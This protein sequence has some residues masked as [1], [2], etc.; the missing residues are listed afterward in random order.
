MSS[1]V[2]RSIVPQDPSL[3]NQ[4]YPYL[5][6]GVPI[7]LS[8]VTSTP[9]T[10]QPE[11]Y[12]YYQG[13]LTEMTG[14]LVHAPVDYKSPHG[15]SG[16][17][18]MRMI[19]I[20]AQLGERSAE[21]QEYTALFIG[22]GSADAFSPMGEIARMQ[23]ANAHSTGEYRFGNFITLSHTLG[24]TRSTKTID[25]VDL[26][27][28]ANIAARGLHHAALER[29]VKLSEDGIVVIG[30]SAGAQMAIELAATL[31]NRC[32][33]LVIIETT[34]TADLPHLSWEFSGGN[35]IGLTRKAITET[36]NITDLPGRVRQDFLGSSTTALGTPSSVSDFVKQSKLAGRDS[37][38]LGATYG[39]ESIYGPSLPNARPLD[40]DATSKARAKLAPHVPVTMVQVLNAHVA[41]NLEARA[42]YSRR[43]LRRLDRSIRIQRDALERGQDAVLT[44]SDIAETAD[45]R[46]LQERSLTMLEELFPGDRVREMVVYRDSIHADLLRNQAF[47]NNLFTLIQADP[48][49]L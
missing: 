24:S 28:S 27:N 32:K 43:Q 1:I 37:Q 7:D 47:W 48:D 30:F 49:T 40:H 36:H 20:P 3:I 29:K 44:E 16:T 39:L 19:D 18:I 38:E 31:G 15:E 23:E 11:R 21:Q 14:N 4:A 45:L 8:E 2:E 12:C 22:G 17:A 42:G 10:I 5:E 13:N 35:M 33:G 41:N 46:E 34:G 6:Q 9:V 26:S 25:S